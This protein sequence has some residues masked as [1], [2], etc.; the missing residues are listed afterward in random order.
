MYYKVG[1]VPQQQEW[2]VSL[3]DIQKLL[4]YKA[5]TDYVHLDFRLLRQLQIQLLRVKSQWV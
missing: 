4:V 1:Q 2:R 5:L 3:L